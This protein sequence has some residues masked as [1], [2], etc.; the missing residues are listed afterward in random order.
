M[1]VETSFTRLTLILTLEAF[2]SSGLVCSIGAHSGFRHSSLTIIVL[3][4]DGGLRQTIVRAVVAHG[5]DLAGS[6]ADPVLV[7]AGGA[8]GL[9]SVLAVVALGTDVSSGAV[10]GRVVVGRAGAVVA[11]GAVGEVSL[12]SVVAASL[13]VLAFRAL[14]TVVRG[15]GARSESLTVRVVSSLRALGGDGGACEAVVAAR[16]G[17]AGG[18]GAGGTVGTEVARVALSRG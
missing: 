1:A 3:I 11:V 18:R 15:F 12:F 4:A 14:K 16:A 2:D 10:D 8:D 9:D 5:T 13:A 6:G 7:G 17:V